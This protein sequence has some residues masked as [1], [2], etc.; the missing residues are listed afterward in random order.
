MS[1][2]LGVS[3]LSRIEQHLTK[4]ARVAQGYFARLKKFDWVRTQVVRPYVRMSWFVFVVTL[5]KGIDRDLVTKVMEAQGIPVRA[6]FSPIHLQ[7]YV[8]K[9]LGINKCQ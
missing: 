6:Y 7:P 1:A 2:A 3:Q 5:A 9:S 4:R 8:K